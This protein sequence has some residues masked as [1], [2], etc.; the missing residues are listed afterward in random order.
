MVAP[1]EFDQQV[2]TLSGIDS[3]LV[4]TRKFLTRWTLALWA[5]I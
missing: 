3:Y 2:E 5:K 4:I 1:R